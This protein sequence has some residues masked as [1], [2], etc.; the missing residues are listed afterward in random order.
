MRFYHDGK[1]ARWKFIS[2]RCRA[3]LVRAS[4]GQSN[5]THDERLNI[6]TMYYDR[7]SEVDFAALLRL[8]RLG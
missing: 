3:S 8:P 6:D 1:G 4:V 5:D 7:H 2:R